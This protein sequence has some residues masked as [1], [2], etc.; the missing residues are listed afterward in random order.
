MIYFIATGR[1]LYTVRA[2]AKSPLLVRVVKTRSYDWLF[3]Q[4]RVSAAAIV[5]SDFERLLYHE[6]LEAAR[7]ANVLREGGVRILNHP[8]FARQRFDLLFQLHKQGINPFQMYRAVCDPKPARFP[9]FV[10]SES[11]HRKILDALYHNQEELNRALGDLRDKGV[12]LQNILVTEFANSPVR[13]GV[14]Q[15]QT[16]Y[17]VGDRFIAAPQVGEDRPFVK[18][19]TRGLAS[20]A[21]FQQGVDTVEANRYPAELE[22]AFAIANIEFGRA[23]YG[24]ENGRMALYEINTNPTIPENPQYRHAGFTEAHAKVLKR[25]Q[26]AILALD[27]PNRRVAIPH[28]LPWFLRLELRYIP[29][30]RR[31]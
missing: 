17:R 6:H 14:W 18:Y 8:A 7:I 20:E 19:G 10:K 25:L 21:E 23:D 2:L 28:R 13:E 27:G 4:S 12:P 3:R 1:H 30:L 22:R 31:T 24:Y 26:E 15:K 11:E 9:V 29:K 5:F 16:A